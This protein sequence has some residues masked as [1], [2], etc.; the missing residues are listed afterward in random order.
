MATGVKIQSAKYGVGT[1]TLDVTRAVS[2]QLV[3]G[4]LNFVVTPSALNVNDPAIGQVKT[5]TVVYTINNG[6]SNTATA[7][8]GDAMTIDAP[9]ARVASGLQ[10]KKAQYG[11]DGNYADVTSA[12]RTYL[13]NGSI[14]MKVSPGSVG[15]PDPNPQKPKFL[16][17][18]Y[19]INGEPSSRKVADGKNFTLHAPAVANNTTETPTEGIMGIFGTIT[20]DIILFMYW[21]F[22]FSM[23]I[24]GAKYGQTLFSG[25]YW[26][27]GGL[28]LITM[29]VFPLIILPIWLFIWTLIMG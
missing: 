5:L 1:R 22:V 20:W 6:A 17:V 7:V 15:I 9:P 21:T 2:A 25:G 16:K 13:N 8:D 10:I 28:S 29:G 18:D 12:V 14:N 4:K 11:Y 26:I 24:Q 19:T 23:T 3:N 27:I